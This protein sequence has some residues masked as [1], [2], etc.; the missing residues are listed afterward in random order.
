MASR[1]Q[2]ELLRIRRMEFDRRVEE[3]R[4][5]MEKFAAESVTTDK[6]RKMLDSMTKQELIAYAYEHEI[7]VDKRAKKSDILEAIKKV[8]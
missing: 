2:R 5:N 6:G 1:K 3:N 8:G 7:E 4:R